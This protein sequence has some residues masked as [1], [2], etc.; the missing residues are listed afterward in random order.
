MVTGNFHQ[1]NTLKYKCV[2][3]LTKIFSVISCRLTETFFIR[4]VIDGHVSQ[5]IMS[6][7]SRYKLFSDRPSAA[8]LFII[9]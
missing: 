4:C 7:R 1:I 2:Y 9:L 5:A 6:V 8:F 3:R